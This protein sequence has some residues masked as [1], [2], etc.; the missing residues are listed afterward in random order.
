MQS[1]FIIPLDTVLT[2]LFVLVRISAT[3]LFVPF[4]GAARVANQ[5]KVFI[6]VLTSVAVLP[7]A[8]RIHAS[9]IDPAVLAGM[10]LAETIFGIAVG[11]IVSIAAEAF[12]FGAQ[13]LS[14]QAGLSFA[15]TID[16]NTEADSTV[17]ATIAQL[18]AGCF[19]FTF[20]IDAH[21]LRAL[22]H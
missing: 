16:P 20:G 2:F 1:S 5:A 6:C 22:V 21:V 15:A 10:L 4:P 14:L 3:F 17:L 11:L 9:N 13:M 8:D 19:F 7:Q 12:Q 18:M